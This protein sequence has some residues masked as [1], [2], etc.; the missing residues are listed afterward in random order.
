MLRGEL[1][2][3]SALCSQQE[4]LLLKPSMYQEDK[5]FHPV[6][7]GQRSVHFLG[8]PVQLSRLRPP[9]QNPHQGLIPHPLKQLRERYTRKRH[10]WIPI[11]SQHFSS[12][13]LLIQTKH[14]NVHSSPVK[15]DSSNFRRELLLLPQIAYNISCSLYSI[16]F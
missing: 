13:C 1:L 2:L 4:C 12:F 14:F 9:C 7:S 5:G 11:G 16:E 8:H 3:L 15:L 6:T 10:F